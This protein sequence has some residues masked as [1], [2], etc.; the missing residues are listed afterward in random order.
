LLEGRKA[1]PLALTLLVSV[2]HREHNKELHE[3]AVSELT[4]YPAVKVG[5]ARSH[6]KVTLFDLGEAD[7]VV[8]EGSANAR[9][10]KNREQLA[11]IR[12]RPLHDFHAAWIDDLVKADTDGKEER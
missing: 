8:F 9:S 1:D 3:W 6:C 4:Q 7:A 12:D 10:N 5:A 11:V 2:F